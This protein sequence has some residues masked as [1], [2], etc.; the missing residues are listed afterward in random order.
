[1]YSFHIVY[2]VARQWEDDSNIFKGQ[3]FKGRVINLTYIH[4]QKKGFD[5]L[6]Y[7]WKGFNIWHFI[8]FSQDLPI[9]KQIFI[10]WLW[11]WPTFENLQ[12]LL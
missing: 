5:I 12:R 2:I 7:N 4:F 6:L 9:R 1:M 10:L 8:S 3:K 11:L